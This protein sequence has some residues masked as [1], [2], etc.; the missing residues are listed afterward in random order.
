[1]FDSPV[2]HGRYEARKSSQERIEKEK[3]TLLIV[4][5]IYFV[6]F[7]G[8]ILM[9]LI[10]FFGR[11]IDEYNFVQHICFTCISFIGFVCIFYIIMLFY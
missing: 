8:S 5:W 9:L 1:M 4:I 6:S 3:N 11:K 10:G 7:L 2:Q